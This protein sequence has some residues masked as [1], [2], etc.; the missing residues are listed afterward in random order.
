M[1]AKSRPLDWG[2]PTVGDVCGVK[3]DQYIYISYK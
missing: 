3:S 1:L 2:H